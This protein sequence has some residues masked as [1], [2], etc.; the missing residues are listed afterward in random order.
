MLINGHVLEIPY[1]TDILYARNSHETFGLLSWILITGAVVMWINSF[2]AIK[3]LSAWIWITDD[4][5][6]ITFRIR[7]KNTNTLLG[8]LRLVLPK[9]HKN[10]WIQDWCTW[11]RTDNKRK[12]KRSSEDYGR[13]FGL[14]TW[15]IEFILEL[16]WRM[17]GLQREKDAWDI[18]RCPVPLWCVGQDG[19]CLRCSELPEPW[20]DKYNHWTRLHFFFFIQCY[21]TVHLALDCGWELWRL[22]LG[23]RDNV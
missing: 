11:I 20:R 18:A 6:T 15:L 17:F 2:G 7:L 3:N 14:M 10:W 5:T 4:P 22:F 1:C 13:V 23:E 16:K 19:M 12:W 8:W 21:A 9:E